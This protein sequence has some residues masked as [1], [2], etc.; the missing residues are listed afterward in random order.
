MVYI[1]MEKNHG[2]LKSTYD[3]NLKSLMWCGTKHT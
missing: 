3:R 1:N 2:F